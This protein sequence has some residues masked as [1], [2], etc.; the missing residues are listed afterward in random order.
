MNHNPTFSEEKFLWQETQEYLRTLLA[1]NY[2][3][4][5]VEK[6]RWYL[7]NFLQW[8]ESQ[9]LRYAGEIQR[10]HLLA[11][12]HYLEQYHRKDTGEPLC[13]E[14]KRRSFNTV[15]VLFTYIYK[16]L[17]IPTNPTIGIKLF[18][19]SQGATR[20]GLSE[21]LIEL[22]MLEPNLKRPL[23]VRDRA[24]LETLYS[25]GIRRM[26]LC[27]IHLFDLDISQGLLTIRQGKGSKD[28]LVPIGGRAIFWLERYLR[29]VRPYL[30]KGMDPQV[31]FLGRDGPPL[32]KHSISQIVRNHK[33]SAGIVAVGAAHLLRHS[34]ASV[35]LKN[36][37]Q[38]QTIQQF[39]GHQSL[40]TTQIYAGVNLSKL[41]EAYLVAHPGSES[42]DNP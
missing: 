36:G 42:G 33:K 12:G 17:I 5:T 2:S 34:A 1:R 20:R 13:L 22:I 8:C 39:L 30:V 9:G 27:N 14:R 15:T 19:G 18:A 6:K 25:T 40:S 11:Y 38:I 10:T 35:M 37:A 7:K 3:K 31:L 28:R 32:G 26:E 29:E 23:G 16:Q 4:E 24:I 21:E 41:K